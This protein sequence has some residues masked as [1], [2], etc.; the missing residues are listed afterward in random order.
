M[1]SEKWK[2]TQIMCRKINRIICG[3][4]KYEALNKNKLLKRQQIFIK[5]NKHKV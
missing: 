5:T 4:V 1:I 3:V 2:L